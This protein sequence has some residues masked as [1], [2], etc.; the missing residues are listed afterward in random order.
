MSGWMWKPDGKDYRK[1]QGWRRF[2]AP[3]RWMGWEKPRLPG[4]LT[5][6][7]A[8]TMVDSLKQSPFTNM[9]V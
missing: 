7:C 5:V 8:D 1:N 9:S 3:E 2:K 4:P 6:T